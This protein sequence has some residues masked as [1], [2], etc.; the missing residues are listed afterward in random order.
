VGNDRRLEKLLNTGFKI[1]AL[2]NSVLGL[3]HVVLG[4]DAEFSEI[5]TASIFDVEDVPLNYWHC[6]PRKHGVTSKNRINN[7][8]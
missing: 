5:L 2:G 4:D 8:N 6:H 1:C 3:S 7:R